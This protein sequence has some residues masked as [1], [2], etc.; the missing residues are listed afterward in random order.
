MYILNRQMGYLL[1]WEHRLVFYKPDFS[2]TAQNYS[3]REPGKLQL[4]GKDRQE[5]N[6]E[7]RLE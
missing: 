7:N 1:K 5:M 2:D 4:E 6:T 3:Y